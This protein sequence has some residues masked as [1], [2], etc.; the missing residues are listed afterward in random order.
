VQ[1]A[2]HDTSQ[3]KGFHFL[4][5]GITPVVRTR[6]AHRLLEGL[7]AHLSGHAHDQRDTHLRIDALALVHGD[8]AVLAP[9]DMQTVMPLLERRLNANGLRLVDRPWVAIDP[10]TGELVVPEPTL[11]IDRSALDGLDELVPPPRRADPPVAPG[12]Y[13]IVGWGFGRGETDAGPL[14]TA[15]AVVCAV[16]E[17]LNLKRV[18][19]QR[20]LDGLTDTLRGAKKVALWADD[21]EG[22]VDH[23]AAL[24]SPK[25]RR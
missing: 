22:L 1:L 13:R 11:D 15:S 23:L 21:P 14:S 4:Y 18:G 7:F 16:D 24:A 6:D 10:A 25:S 17:V 19:A 9:A 2:G 5:R 20:V 12:R 8:T 3:S